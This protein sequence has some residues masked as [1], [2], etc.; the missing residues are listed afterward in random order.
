MHGGCGCCSNPSPPLPCSCE[1]LLLSAQG[2]PRA[3][4]GL[5]L[6]ARPEAITLP[7]WGWLVGG[8]WAQDPGTRVL[9]LSWQ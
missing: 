8:R 6:E 2:K 7:W 9:N 5:H 1:R 4:G 3:G